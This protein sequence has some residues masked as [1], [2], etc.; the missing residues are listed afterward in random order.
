M[1]NPPKLWKKDVKRPQGRP[2]NPEGNIQSEQ[3][4]STWDTWSPSS[5]VWW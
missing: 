3:S 4:I 5:K 2:R 1:K